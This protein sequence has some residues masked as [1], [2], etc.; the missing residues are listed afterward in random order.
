MRRPGAQEGDYGVSGSSRY[1]QNR[2]QG[3][4]ILRRI[5]S[6]FVRLRPASSVDL[7]LHVRQRRHFRNRRPPGRALQRS[8]V[9]GLFRLDPHLRP[10]AAY[11]KHPR[12]QAHPS[13]ARYPHPRCSRPTRRNG[14][15]SL[16]RVG[17]GI[18]LRRQHAA[19][20]FGHPDG[21]G[22]FHLAACLGHRLLAA[23]LSLHHH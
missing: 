1:D 11:R 4:R 23:R 7:Q 2:L 21:N 6:H 9:P 10:A 13:A 3:R 8:A 15:A 14:N 16:A 22:L 12:H 20:H 18:A 19:N 17:R 5:K